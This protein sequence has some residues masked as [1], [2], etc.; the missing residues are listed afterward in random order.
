MRH[1]GG[2]TRPVAGMDSL[3]ASVRDAKLAVAPARSNPGA[4]T[5]QPAGTQWGT[6][7]KALAGP[8]LP[9]R[10]SLGARMPSPLPPPQTFHGDLGPSDGITV[11]LA[12]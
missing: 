12:A 7:L 8:L 4:D 11:P 2:M 1:P 10:R 3:V 5:R 9:W 6:S